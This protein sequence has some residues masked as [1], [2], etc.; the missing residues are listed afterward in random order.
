MPVPTTPPAILTRGSW[1]DAA[2]GLRVHRAVVRLADGTSGP[3]ITLRV[4][5]PSVRFGVVRAPGDRLGN[6]LGGPVRA[7]VVGGFFEQDR[8]PSGVLEAAGT[9]HG[10][11]RPQ[12]GSGLLLVK[13]GIASVLASSV[14]STRWA[15]A[16]IAVQSGPRLVEPGPVVG[17]RSDRGD[18]YA[19]AAACVRDG[20]ATLDFVVTWSQQDPL[21]GPGL[22]SFALALAGPSPA[23]D[24]SGCET[25]VNLD[26]GPSA[27]LHLAGSV[28]GTHAP[29]GPVPWAIVLGP[30]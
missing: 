20:G 30:R 11:H 17:I 27:G 3:W 4:S 9:I 29:L 5:V 13:D 22:L 2:P 7:A 6:A 16:M 25:A 1:R 8:S 15:G 18:R 26:G 21:R 10:Q 14:A 12:G 24:A 19:R 28:E 23:G